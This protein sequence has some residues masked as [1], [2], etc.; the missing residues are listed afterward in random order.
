MVQ[1]ET[2]SRYLSAIFHSTGDPRLGKGTGSNEGQVFI[3]SIASGPVEPFT[4]ERMVK[5]KVIKEDPL[6]FPR[7]WVGP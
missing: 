5:R 1:H 3:E 4:T 2:D 7:D 6:S